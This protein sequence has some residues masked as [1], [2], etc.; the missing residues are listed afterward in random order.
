MK[1]IKVTV[2][3]AFCIVIAISLI[4]SAISFLGYRK[5]ID[6]VNNIQASKSNQD[7]VQ[8]LNQFSTERQ[9]VLTHMV[10][11]FDDSENQKFVE[12]G[13]TLDVT[14]KKLDKAQI[15][16]DDKK[17]VQ[18]LININK[19]YTDIYNS[20][21]SGNI[22]PFEKKGI[23]D[24][25]KNIE[26][27]FEEAKNIEDEL[28]KAV[29]GSLTDSSQK[30]QD[31][32]IE[33]N[34]LIGLIDSDSYYVDNQFTEIKKL[35]ADI[36]A[37]I[38]I[39]G[40][41]AAVPPNADINAKI[42]DLEQRISAAADSSGMILQNSQSSQ[43]FDR[44]QNI[45]KVVSDLKFY[46]EVNDLAILTNRNNAILLY[47]ASNYSDTSSE[48]Q[49]NQGNIGSKLA[50][51]KKNGY[52]KE[53]I[54]KLISLNKDISGTAQE[55]YKR[56]VI[57]K[58]GSIANGYNSMSSLN[59][60]FQDSI[61]KLRLSFN[62]YFSDDI[63]SSEK[64]KQAIFWIFIGI[65]LFSII[66]GMVIAF[67]L[68]NKISKPIHYLSNILSKVEKGDLTVRAEITANSEIGNLGKQVNSVLD[69]QQRMVEQF[70]D[71]SSEIGSLKQRLT[72]L[73]DQN[74]ESIERISG[75]KSAK[76]LSEGFT[77]D[78]ES[79][80][81]DVR[82]V[83]EQT[84]KA[85]GDSIRAVEVAKSREKTV[86]EAEMFIN[87]VNETVKSIAL[88]IGKLESSSGKI[89]EITNT[90]TQI[91]SQTN[92]LA[93]NAAIE[94]N[95][96]GQQGKGFAV[97]A[98]EIRKLSNASN[99]SAGEIKEQIIEIQSSISMA[100]EKM[101]VGLVGVE[102]GATRINEVKEG[103]TEIIHSINQVTDAIKSSAD[104][105][106][107]HYQS[108]REFVEVVGKIAG[109]SKETARE[110][111]SIDSIVQ[112]QTKT[113]KDLDDIT[114]LLHEASSEL[115]K[116]SDRVKI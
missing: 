72:S 68:S 105:A 65:T 114:M 39:S 44:V 81:S 106:Y 95:R 9:Q 80:I 83:T 45:K 99:K 48:F 22:K 26:D 16:P 84:Q 15:S 40:N 60:S 5:V 57:L 17:T 47:A 55:V 38:S 108:T 101:N 13:N 64:I 109:S 10:S 36:L 92:L 28:M 23:P 116:I 102:D 59:K 73:V 18:E 49:K 78:T 74:R 1:N 27:N 62:N 6:S 96:A 50:D 12:L 52:D 46:M 100:V 24:F 115:F 93:L 21:I 56:A 53:K 31:D 30:A 35:L 58:K 90:I 104:K 89:G 94:A 103:I 75:T 113:L 98:D 7:M 61:G 51:L 67:L 8:E 42:E 97:V 87:S 86:E 2:V 85:V 37:Q 29:S 79:I 20:Q 107:T 43:G 111:G 54:D 32:V 76:I 11:S 82:T 19:Q 41:E 70:K 88:S 66:I 34:R 112:I 14:V 69:G 71:T 77:L 110:E 25:L 63:K 33:L 4:S 3:G 91:A